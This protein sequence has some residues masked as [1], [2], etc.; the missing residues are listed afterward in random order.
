M[1]LHFLFIISFTTMGKK[2]VAIFRVPD[3]TSESYY[4]ILKDLE[5]NGLAHPTGRLSHVA[6]SGDSGMVVIDT[7]DSQEA[8]QRF[9]DG[10]MPILAKNGVTPPQ[11]E[12]TVI[13]NEV[14]P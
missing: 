10:L 2:I 8:L 9:G 7:Y 6:T 12:V 3:M 11:P 13:E 1:S 4:Q 14:T 5:A